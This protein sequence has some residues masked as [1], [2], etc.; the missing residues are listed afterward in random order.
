MHTAI[1]WTSKEMLNLTNI[2]CL[3]SKNFP[4]ELL[5][6]ISGQINDK[7]FV[8]IIKIAGLWTTSKTELECYIILY[9]IIYVMYLYRIYIITLYGDGL[10][11][12]E[13]NWKLYIKKKAINNHV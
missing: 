8:L 2:R 11:H 4:D 6:N 7:R 9:Y 10:K 13:I 1:L 5:R 12:F 3:R